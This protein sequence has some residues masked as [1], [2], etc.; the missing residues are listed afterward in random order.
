MVI[1]NAV[2]VLIRGGIGGLGLGTAVSSLLAVDL[3]SSM[4]EG[5]GLERAGSIK[6]SASGV[7]N[8]MSSVLVS[9]HLL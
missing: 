5:G 9:L 3:A 2:R 1:L 4:Q 6:S 7:W 8:S